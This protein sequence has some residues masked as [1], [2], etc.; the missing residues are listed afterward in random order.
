MDLQLESELFSKDLKNIQLQNEEILKQAYHSIQLC[1]TTLY[2]FKKKIISK[3][4]DSM[5]SE[6]NFFKIIKQIPLVQLIYYS[7]IHSF[8]IQLPKGDKDAQLKSI[9]KKINKLN[10][11]FSY[12][13]DFGRYVNSGATLFD[14]EYYT[15]DYLETFHITTSK[16]YFQ[17]PE[18]CTPRDMLLGKY[19]AYDLL[20]IY[21]D[22][23]KHRIRKG[24]NDKL[25]GVKPLEKIHWPFSNTDYVEMVYALCSK[26]LGKQDNQSIM[27]VSKKLQQLFDI[28][29]KDIYKTFQDIKNRKNSRTL[30]LDDLSA[31]LLIE[32]DKREE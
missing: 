3:G 19:K 4:F 1:R 25:N 16:F 2:K 29:P 11:F 12:N 30:F 18:F 31:S 20:V 13:I 5:E 28:E 22:E 15:R 32:M 23:K 8:E 6:I 14:K 9:K 26:G 17:D 10:R 21:L 7:E 24:L 27:Q